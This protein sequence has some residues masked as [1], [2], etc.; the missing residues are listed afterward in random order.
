[1][2]RVHKISD[3]QFTLDCI[4]K[5][6]EVIGESL[7]WNTF[8]ELSAWVK[9]NPDWYDRYVI[10]SQEQYDAWKNYF[11]E[12]FYDWK[13][14][15]ISKQRAEKEFSWFALNYGFIYDFPYEIV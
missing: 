13:P 7:H 3:K 5:E 14:K 4:N 10:T 9:E 11:L 12:H 6:F 1:M 2:A 8:E 15:Y